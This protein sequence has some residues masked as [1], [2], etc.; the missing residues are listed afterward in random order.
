MLADVIIMNNQDDDADR[1]C[2]FFCEPGPGL[3]VGERGGQ[4][5]CGP[6]LPALSNETPVRRVPESGLGISLMQGGRWLHGVWKE[7]GGQAGLWENVLSA[8]TTCRTH[9][10]LIFCS[11]PGLTWS[12]KKRVLSVLYSCFGDT[13]SCG[14]EPA[15]PTQWSGLASESL[16]S[17]SG[18]RLGSGCADRT[19]CQKL[20][21]CCELCVWLCLPLGCCNKTDGRN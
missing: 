5:S 20:I 13:G 8:V 18:A 21:R 19:R 6:G 16:R 4:D 7:S 1:D 3:P 2:S 12:W 10:H 11:Q 15:F 17:V 14:F 9:S